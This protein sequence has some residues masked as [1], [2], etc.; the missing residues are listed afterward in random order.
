VACRG[1]SGRG[2]FSLLKRQE[3]GGGEQEVAAGSPGS[4]TQVLHEEDKHTFAKS[5]FGF[6]VFSGKYK[7]T[8][9]CTIW[10]FKLV[11]KTL[12][13]WTGTFL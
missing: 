10:W 7:T 6:G 2:V 5:S 11:L 4:S 13:R 9:F 1:V 8:P 3:A 12:G